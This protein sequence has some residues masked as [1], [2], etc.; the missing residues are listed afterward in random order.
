MSVHSLA[1][2][3]WLIT[4]RGLFAILCGLAI[5]TWPTLT[6]TALMLLFAAFLI[7]DGILAIVAGLSRYHESQRW[8]LLLIE[9][10][11]GILTGLLIFLSSSFAASTML[12]LI[13]VWAVMAAMVKMVSAIRLRA[14]IHNEGFLALSGILVAALAILLAV[15]QN[16]GTGSLVWVIG[17]YALLSGLLVSGLGL[18]LWNWQSLEQLV[19]HPVRVNPRQHRKL[20]E[21]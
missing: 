14:D 4:L 1:R 8:W 7:T 21:K 6:L 9:G 16:P 2:N 15:W 19:L 18:R 5:F 13:T 11:A 20:L 17:I 12:Y 10:S 3:W